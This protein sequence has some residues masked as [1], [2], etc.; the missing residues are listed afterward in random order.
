MAYVLRVLESYPRERVTFFMPQLV[1]S[2]R[3]DKGGIF[4]ELPKEVI[5]ICSYPHLAFAG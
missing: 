4:L 5:H 2:L 3:Y 1:Q